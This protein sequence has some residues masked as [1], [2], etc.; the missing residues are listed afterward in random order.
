MGEKMGQLQTT[1]FLERHLKLGA[2]MVEFAGW[3]MPLHYKPGIIQEHLVVRRRAGL[4][5]VSH[6]G[7]FVFR[8]S[9]VLAFLQHTLTNNAA[10][11]EVGESQY[12]IIPNSN[13]GAIDDAYLY[14]FF[15]D[16]YLLVVNAANRQK[17]WE[18]FLRSLE[19]FGQVEMQDRTQEL[20]MLSL[21]GPLSKGI[22]T[23][24]VDSCS[25]PSP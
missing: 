8:G 16:E 25:Y 14:R 12:T 24:I 7:R 21:Q 19:K 10:A 3:N 9:G 6:M 17:D 11:L 23:R 1:V 15:E 20:A 13:G 22:L 4:F 2:K 18:H 5:D